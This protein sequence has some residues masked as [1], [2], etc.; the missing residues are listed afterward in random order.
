MAT[1]RLTTIGVVSIDYP[2][3]VPNRY[4]SEEGQEI[5]VSGDS[6]EFGYDADRRPYETGIAGSIGVAPDLRWLLNGYYYNEMTWGDEGENTT[7]FL[8]VNFR[9]PSLA[10]SSSSVTRYSPV[11]G[12][13][14]PEN[15][16]PDEIGAFFA[17]VTSRTT[18]E[19]FA[20][21]FA[22]NATIVTHDDVF[23]DEYLDGVTLSGGIGDDT[24]IVGRQSGANAYHGG[25]GTDAIQFEDWVR[26]DLATPSVNRGLIADDTFSNIEIFIGSVA[27]ENLRGDAGDNILIGDLGVI[28]LGDYSSIPGLDN[29]PFDTWLFAREPTGDWLFGRAGNDILI[30]GYGDDNLVGGRGADQLW[31]GRDFDTARYSDWQAITIDLANGGFNTGEAEGDTFNSI[32]RIIATN[33]N[34]ILRGDNGTTQFFGQAGNDI[35]RGGAGDDFLHGQNGNDLLAGGAHNDTLR[36]GQGADTFI[37][38]HGDDVIQDFASGVDRLHLV[39]SQLG[40]GEQSI[41]QILDSSVIRD[42]NVVLLFGGEHSLTLNGVSDAQ[43][44]LDDLVLI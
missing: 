19:S 9:T 6:G 36:G 24:F 17:S 37:F 5:T 8:T 18:A 32:E 4:F 30:G 16:T 20:P 15:M 23:Y 38:N 29:I 33:H 22:P 12:D 31:G 40:G 25:E 35:L 28:G 34:D 27:S 11:S 2:A 43:T 1:V 3:N 14:I 7:V 10:P 39:T 42:G 41:A 44:L 13:A 26:I 21:G